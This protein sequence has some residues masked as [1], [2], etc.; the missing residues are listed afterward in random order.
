MPQSTAT[1][2]PFQLG[3]NSTTNQY[4]TSFLKEYPPSLNKAIALMVLKQINYNRSQQ[5]PHFPSHHQPSP[6]HEQ[7]H[8]TFSPYTTPYDEYMEHEL[9]IKH[10][11]HKND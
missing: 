10:D 6:D 8:I 4:N 5:L 9:H 2:T 1:T 7:H 11:Y 3:L